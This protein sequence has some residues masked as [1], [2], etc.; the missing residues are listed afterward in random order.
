MGPTAVHLVLLAHAHL[1]LDLRAVGERRHPRVR[2]EQRQLV[3]GLLQAVQQHDLGVRGCWVG[4]VEECR[5]EREKKERELDLDE[6]GRVKFPRCP[7]RRRR[8]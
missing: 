2:D 1:N 4:G 6:R 7:R 8:N 3:V 5:E